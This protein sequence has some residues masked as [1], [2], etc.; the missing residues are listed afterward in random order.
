MS[1]FT[2]IDN[3]TGWFSLDMGIDLG[4]ANTLVYTKTEGIVLNEPSVVAVKAG[5]NK[6]LKN[7]TAV[8]AAAKEMI[9]FTPSNIVAIRPLKD[10]VIADFEITEAMLRYFIIK[11]HDRSWLVRPRLVIAVPYGI[12]AVERRAVRL[13]AM[14]ANARE[15]RLI[16]EPIAAGIGVDLPISSAT[17]SMIVD[18]GGGTTEVAIMSL[19]GIVYCESLRVAGDEMDEAIIQYMK[20]AYNLAVG[21][22]TAE[23]IKI[24]IGSVYPL[25]EELSMEV[26]GRDLASGLPRSTTITSEEIREA[27]KEPA[28]L[29]LESI[30]NTLENATPELSADLYE[31]GMTLTGGG[32]LIRG[33]DKLIAQETGVPVRVAEDPL[34]A[35]VRGTGRVLEHLDELKD[36]LDTGD[37]G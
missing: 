21:E 5:T 12:T 14:R 23:R 9:G 7:G 27:L 37:D 15:V 31:R 26:R 1:I 32:A 34:T 3:L 36:V 10:G 30:K 33:L 29:I 20:R 22:L 25:E 17:A 18:I 8:G 24:Q 6:V 28:D 4:T 11:V 13:S 2:F 35:V 16:E 19:G